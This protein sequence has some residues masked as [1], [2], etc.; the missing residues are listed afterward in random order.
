MAQVSVYRGGLC[1]LGYLSATSY[2]W[3][4]H[5]PPRFDYLSDPVG[6][7]SPGSQI[8]QFEGLLASFQWD[9]SEAEI[10]RVDFLCAQLVEDFDFCLPYA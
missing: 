3:T 4:V 10:S 2:V 6:L 5:F 8:I 1:R 7:L 9:E